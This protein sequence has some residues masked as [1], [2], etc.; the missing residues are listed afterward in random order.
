MTRASKTQ[1]AERVRQWKASGL[2]AQQYADREG[3]NRG[4][5][6]WWN[7]RLRREAVVPAFVEVTVPV[8]HPRRDDERIEIELTSGVR[9]RVGKFVDAVQLRQVLSA[10]EDR[11]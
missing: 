11:R 1:W 10:L 7:S 9:L 5:L 3:L 6:V 8:Q 2:T 4:T